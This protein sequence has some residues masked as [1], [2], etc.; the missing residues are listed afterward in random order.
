[1][2]QTMPSVIRITL[3]CMIHLQ[4]LILEQTFNLLLIKQDERL[5]LMSV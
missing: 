2:R 3:K 5:C 1:M 4:A